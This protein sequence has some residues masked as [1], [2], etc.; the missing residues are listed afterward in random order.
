MQSGKKNQRPSRARGGQISIRSF[1]RRQW[2]WLLG[3]AFFAALAG[4]ALTHPTSA[5]IAGNSLAG[6]EARP[7]S[8]LVLASERLL[9][10]G[11]Q[12]AAW[13][14]YPRTNQAPADTPGP[15]ASLIAAPPVGFDEPVLAWNLAAILIPWLTCLSM[16]LLCRAAT[17][18]SMAAT[19]AGLGY[20]VQPIVLL[21][22]TT[23]FLLLSPLLPAII[24]GT[25]AAL[26]NPTRFAPLRFFCI[27]LA[28]V[29]APLPIAFTAAIASSIFALQRHSRTRTLAAQ[30]IGCLIVFGFL[31]TLLNPAL[32]L[33]ADPVALIPAGEPIRSFL[34]G[35]TWGPGAV[36]SGLALIALLDR[37]RGARR[38][39]M[40]DP[41]L[42]LLC[43]VVV[44][45]VVLADH[46]G[47]REGSRYFLPGAWL[48][49]GYPVLNSL[50]WCLRLL[51]PL[52]WCSLAAFGGLALLERLAQDRIR[53]IATAGILGGLFLGNFLYPPQPIGQA[54]A[55]TRHLN[56][57]SPP[58][59][60]A[61][62]LEQAGKGALLDLPLGA[63][64]PAAHRLLASAWHRRATTQA[65]SDG[66]DPAQALAPFAV[67]LSR[68][69]GAETLATLGFGN[70]LIHKH[71]LSPEAYANLLR[72]LARSGGAGGRLTTQFESSGH[73]LLGLQGT[74][75]VSENF[76][77]LES[78]QTS[79]SKLTLT[80]PEDLLVFELRVRG[81]IN[82]RN[83]E[84]ETEI[85]LQ[86]EFFDFRRRL[87]SEHLVSGL[88]PVAVARDGT[89]YTALRLPLPGTPGLYTARLA[90]E[91]DPSLTL[92]IQSLE[93]L[94]SPEPR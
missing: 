15:I 66:K 25:H 12:P 81:D 2:P 20:A 56:F 78:N 32:L 76:D 39:P 48:E 82:F 28:L 71:D 13:P 67:A 74:F 18:N 69:D 62:L 60:E 23:T 6:S 43:A 35:G 85:P 4:P 40:G 84:P 63:P 41:R 42:L 65:S 27:A 5:I 72:S 47:G 55:Q 1:L 26:E 30:M 92:A 21:E 58:D 7:F 19:I 64:D 77:V 24:L 54:P 89:G 91:S 79:A 61:R 52:S 38:A 75:P 14:G 51:L 80:G 33:P 44:L 37:I 31:R 45:P 36:I 3:L 22:P 17:A 73:L 88:I 86:V 93:I 70:I 16:I 87:V 59:E 10:I 68:P 11:D 53:R 50:R 57:L 49:S 34:P 46:A 90:P 94:P 83:P 29:W 8:L 9:A